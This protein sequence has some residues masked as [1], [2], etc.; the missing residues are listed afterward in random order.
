MIRMHEERG[1]VLPVVVMLLVVM[2]GM[3]GLAIDVGRLYI[4]KAELSRAADAAALAGVLDLPDNAAAEARAAAYLNENVPDATATF[5]GGDPNGL[6][7]RAER[8]VHLGFMSILGIESM[9]IEAQASAGFSGV[10][11]DSAIILDATGSMGDAPCN[12]AQSNS[13]CPI[14]EAKDA[15]LGFT[16]MLLGGSAGLA[17]VSFA[18]Y[19]GCYNPP[20]NKPNCVPTS[21]IVDFTSSNAALTTGIGNT[22]STGGSGTNVCLGLDQALSMFK[23][24]SAQTGS[25]VVRSVVILT[26]GDNN[27]NAYSYGTGAPTASCRP[28]TNPAQSDPSGSCTSSQTRERELD[29][30][31]VDVADQLEALD[32][33]VYVVAFGTCG[34]DDGTLESASWCG[35]IGDT[36]ND[37]TADRRLL[38]CIASSTAG[39][40]DHYFEVPTATD[41]PEVFER[42]ARAIGF[43]LTE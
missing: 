11:S 2:I 17:Q 40:N 22:N 10:P 37:N 6:R 43:R 19:R 13:G 36:A 28:N 33:S 34:T 21:M 3:L 1:Q 5:P 16:G 39:T 26:D 9:D 31:T 35:N 7:I 29:R 27:Y 38:K 32:V 42:I 18:P 4:A 14:K 30:K 15:A 24:A 41:L 8:T 25:N 12:S 23:G 20:L